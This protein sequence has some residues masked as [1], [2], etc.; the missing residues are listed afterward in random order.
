MTE[1][2]QSSPNANA[3][4]T[5]SALLAPCA[6]QPEDTSF[7]V[8]KRPD[9]EYNLLFD[10]CA[11]LTVG[12]KA[13]VI[14]EHENVYEIKRLVDGSNA[15]IFYKHLKSDFTPINNEGC[16]A[17]IKE[18]AESYKTMP[19]QELSKY[20]AGLKIN[21]QHEGVIPYSMI[22][23][24]FVAVACFRHSSV[25]STTEIKNS[26]AKL[27]EKGIIIEISKDIAQNI[28]ETTAKLYKVV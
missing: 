13:F 19:F 15:K 7:V 18:F 26:I 17:K 2:I 14:V 11:H 25:G 27:I 9:I 1:Y 21:W 10:L 5:H 28:Y 4:Q 16:F 23:R 3:Y 24:K 22:Q 12:K 8:P 6:D 20:Y